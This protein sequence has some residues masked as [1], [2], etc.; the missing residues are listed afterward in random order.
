MGFGDNNV[1]KER[2]INTKPVRKQRQ[3][4]EIPKEK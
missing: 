3:S 1:L 4:V 2:G